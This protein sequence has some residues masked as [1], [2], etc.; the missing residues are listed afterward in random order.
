MKFSAFRKTA[1]ASG[2]NGSK[3]LASRSFMKSVVNQSAPTRFHVVRNRHRLPFV[4]SV[5]ANGGSAS[6]DVVNAFVGEKIGQLPS[7]SRGHD[8]LEGWFDKNGMPVDENTIVTE[9]LSVIKPV[10]TPVSRL[11][12]LASTDIEGPS[13]INVWNGHELN[14]AGQLPRAAKF[15]DLNF[16]GWYTPSGDKVTGS[17]IYDGS[18]STL[19]AGYSSM[20]Y[21][22]DTSYGW[23]H[24]DDGLSDVYVSTHHVDNFAQKLRIHVSGYEEFRVVIRSEAESS[25]DYTVALV[26]DYEPSE[27]SYDSAA[28][29]WDYNPNAYMSTC[30]R[31]WEDIEV[32]YHLDGGEHDLWFTF[33]KDGSVSEDPDIGY[34]YVPKGQ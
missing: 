8:W 31:Q 14:S 18:Y 25:Y 20:Y 2:G 27:D 34:V 1:A 15:G 9:D 6:V 12:F 13:E 4:V 32:T 22:V 19:E 29:E 26:P 3:F 28:G 7:A 10:Y 23:E 11:L 33:R 24:R 17:T 5:D 16:S 30:G 21:E